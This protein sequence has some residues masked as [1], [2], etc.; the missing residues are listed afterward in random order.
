MAADIALGKRLTA[1]LEFRGL[2]QADFATKV[3]KTRSTVSYWCTDG[4]Y[5]SRKA[6]ESIIRALRTTTA[7]FYGPLPSR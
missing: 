6:M 5:P 2:S 4:R 3:G 1:W 7:K